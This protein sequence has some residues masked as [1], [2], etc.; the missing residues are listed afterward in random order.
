[1]TP[2]EADAEMERLVERLQGRS[3]LM[4]PRHLKLPEWP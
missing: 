2:E 3:G 4:G 1:M